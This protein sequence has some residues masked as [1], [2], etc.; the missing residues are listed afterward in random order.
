M[1][2][3]EKCYTT[4]QVAAYLG[5]CKTSVRRWIQEGRLGAVDLGTKE[6]PGPY[7]IPPE[8]LDA[9]MRARHTRR[10]LA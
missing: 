1:E 6:R 4:D 7:R 9:Y 3:L 5:V 8:D 2:N 10:K